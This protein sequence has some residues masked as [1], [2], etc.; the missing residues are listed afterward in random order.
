[1]EKNINDLESKLKGK[2]V[3]GIESIMDN[4]KV[5]KE[6]LDYAEKLGIDNRDVQMQVAV[7]LYT[8]RHNTSLTNDIKRI[9][10]NVVFFFWAVFG[11]W[12]VLFLIAISGGFLA[13]ITSAL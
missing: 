1:M 4:K 3:V 7:A 2:P 12:I 11:I 10:N 5:W 13:A 6:C 8:N 9:K